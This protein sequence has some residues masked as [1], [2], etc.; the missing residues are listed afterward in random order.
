VVNKERYVRGVAHAHA[1]SLKVV[2]MIAICV[3]MYVAII[4]V[5]QRR[6]MNTISAHQ[7][8]VKSMSLH[9][10]EH[11]LVTGSSDGNVKIWD[12]PSLSSREVWENV[13]ERT[14][15][16]RPREM[17]STNNALFTCGVMRVSFA[18]A[19]TLYS[20]GSDGRYLERIMK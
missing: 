8:T 13:H 18:D 9:P 15:F 19:S 6:I 2:L 3:S 4:D 1:G 10:Q 12:L 17:F 5:R 11:L 20:C 16:V 14:T 7:G